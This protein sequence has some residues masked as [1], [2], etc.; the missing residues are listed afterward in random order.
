MLLVII[1]IVFD[2]SQPEIDIAAH[3]GGLAA[4]LWLGAIVPPTG[5]P[6]LTSLWQHPP[7]GVRRPGL[8][9]APPYVMALGLVVVGVAVVA[10]VAYGT[11]E[12]SAAAHLSTPPA[13]IQVDDPGWGP[14]PAGPV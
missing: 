2:L 4:G 9:T 10:G 6:T 14:P 13:I 12:R 7:D 1:N 11:A 8:A 5:V 3:L